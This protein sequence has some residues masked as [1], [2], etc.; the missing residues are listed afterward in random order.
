MDE[1]SA[2]DISSGQSISAI[3][4]P[5]FKIFAPLLLKNKEA[6][7]SIPPTTHLYGSHPRQELDVYR[8]ATDTLATPVL[9]FCH[10]GGLIRGDKNLAQFPDGLVYANVGAF[11]AARGVT[12]IVPNYRRVDSEFGGEGAV[13]PSGGED[14][15][16]VL[17]WLEGFMQGPGARDVFLMGN[18]A[19]GVHVSTF[20]LEP[21]FLEQRLRYSGDREGGLVVRGVVQLAVPCHFDSADSSRADVLERYYG[22]VEEAKGKCVCGLLESVKRTG[23]GRGELGIPGRMLAAVGEFDPVDEIKGPMEDFVK[24]W[25]EA[26]GGEGLV[27]QRLKGHNHISPPMSLMS[28]EREGEAW[29]EHVVRWIQAS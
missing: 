29:G 16:A 13:F 5:T 3:L 15:A 28:G 21:R 1:I 27:E 4:L 18:S 22:G 6:I 25:K 19:G 23:K 10:G 17:G 24:M 2:L 9:V 8:A 12:T 26:F 11:F 7:K 14:V 20:L